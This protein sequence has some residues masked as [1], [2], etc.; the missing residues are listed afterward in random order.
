[1]TRLQAS[2]K[3]FLAEMSAGNFNV[4]LIQKNKGIPNAFHV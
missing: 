1:M 3:Q 4:L 2:E